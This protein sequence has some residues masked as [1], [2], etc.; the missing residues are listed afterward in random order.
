MQPMLRR[1]QRR[2]VLQSNLIRL[3]M[4]CFG[5]VQSNNRKAASVRAEIY[6]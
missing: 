6:D 5:V 4:L 3:A 1:E 2:D